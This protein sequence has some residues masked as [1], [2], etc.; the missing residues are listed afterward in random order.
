MYHKFN[1]GT[2][3]QLNFIGKESLLKRDGLLMM[4]VKQEI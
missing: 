1:L 4:K 2:F 3:K